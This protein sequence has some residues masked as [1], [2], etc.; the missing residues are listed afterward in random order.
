MKLLN[1]YSTL[2]DVGRNERSRYNR[3]AEKYCYDRCCQA[4]PR[5]HA[6]FWLTMHYI[7]GL[8]KE[9]NPQRFL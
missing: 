9:K 5:E 6:M 8:M 1:K 3:K 2:E 4:R 7:Y